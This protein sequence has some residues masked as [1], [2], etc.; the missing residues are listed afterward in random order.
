M[1]KMTVMLIRLIIFLGNYLIIHF[2]A[3]R[4]INLDSPNHIGLQLF[5]LIIMFILALIIMELMVYYLRK[6]TQSY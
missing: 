2:V 6:T 5:T 3:F 1:E 4:L